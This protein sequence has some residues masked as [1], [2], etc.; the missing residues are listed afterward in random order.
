MSRS[1]RARRRAPLDIDALYARHADALL[2][3]FAR[4][5]ADG[6]AALDLWAETFAAA[7]VSASRFRG[8]T[9][10]EEAGWLYGIARNQLALFQRRGQAE[11]RALARL[12]LQRPAA[13]DSFVAEIERRAELAQLRAAL[14]GSLQGLSAAVAEAVRLRVVGELSFKEVAGR[15]SISEEAARARVSRGLSALAESLNPQ[16]VDEVLI[17]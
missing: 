12:G 16:D 8:S 6:E 3:W 17:P 10:E 14:N 13:D 15:L 4:R 9:A 5:T 11:R 7:V 1:S 2:R